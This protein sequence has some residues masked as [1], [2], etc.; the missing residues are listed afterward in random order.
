[1]TKD[2]EKEDEDED[3]NPT[4]AKKKGLGKKAT[5]KISSDESSSEEEENQPPIKKAPLPLKSTNQTPRDKKEAKKPPLKTSAK[6]E[7]FQSSSKT[8]REAFKSPAT[9]STASI[10][11]SSPILG[12]AKP[13]NIQVPKWNPPAL[14]KGSSRTSLSPSMA[15]VNISPGFRV[16]LS[17]NV[18]V[19]SLHPNVKM[20]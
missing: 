13:K 1:M 18:R 7:D 12:V 3:F 5:L 15:N 8:S 19:K 14:I 20:Q 17:R 6:K 16:G 4:S 10:G 2:G 11:A 9:A